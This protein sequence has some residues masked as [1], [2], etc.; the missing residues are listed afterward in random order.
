MTFDATM[1]ILERDT[2]SHFDPAV[3]AA[4]LPMAREIYERLSGSSEAD[5]RQLLEERIRVHFEM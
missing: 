2:G 1:A 3:M 5:A 4:F